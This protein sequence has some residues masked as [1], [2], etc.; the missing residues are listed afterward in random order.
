MSA[1]DQLERLLYVLPRA[2]QPDGAAIA[3]LARALEVEPSD[4]LADITALLQELA[5]KGVVTA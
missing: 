1:R 5:D 3:D 2:A 4:I